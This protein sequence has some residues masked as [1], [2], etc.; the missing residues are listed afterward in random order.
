M[1]PGRFPEA[2]DAAIHQL[3]TAWPDLTQVTVAGPERGVW[4]VTAKRNN[5]IVQRLEVR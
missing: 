2:V 1:N 3:Y 4:R 5:R